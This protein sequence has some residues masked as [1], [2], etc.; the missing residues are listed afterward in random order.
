[1][2]LDQRNDD[3]PIHSREL[4]VVSAPSEDPSRLPQG[5][6]FE[7][8]PFSKWIL[9][10]SL[11][12]ATIFTTLWAGAYQAYNGPIRGPVNLLLEQPEILWS[13]IPFAATLL[14]ILV[15]HEFGHYAL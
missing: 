15:T 9:P 7:E 2:N 10:T 4:P 11:F 6:E 3:Q 5:D 13:G 1:M 8:A 12:V 14:T